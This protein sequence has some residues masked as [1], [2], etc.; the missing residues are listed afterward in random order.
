M[1]FLRCVLAIG[2]VSL[3]VMEV[4]AKLKGDDCEGTVKMICIYDK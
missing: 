2:L 1:E 4:R 3:F